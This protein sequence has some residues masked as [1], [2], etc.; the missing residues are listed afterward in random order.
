M[1]RFP[2]AIAIDDEVVRL[3]Y[4]V[5]N[6][7]RAE[8]NFGDDHASA[9]NAQ[10]QVLNERLDNDEVHEKY[11]EDTEDFAD[12]VFDAAMDAQGWM[13]G[14]TTDLP[15]DGWEGLYTPREA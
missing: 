15:S 11:G 9:I 6:L 2:N 13:H 12:N 4:I 7:T 5:D 14:D 8:S 10:I 1:S 3:R